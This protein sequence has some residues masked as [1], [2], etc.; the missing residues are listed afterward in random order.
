MANL[1]QRILDAL[2]IEKFYTEVGDLVLG[3]TGTDYTALCCFH[4]ES[5]PSLVIRKKDGVF[6]CFGCEATGS[7]FDF[8]A[9]LKGVD[10]KEALGVLAEFAGVENDEAEEASDPTIGDVEEWHKALLKNKTRL[11]W[12]LDKRGITV[13]TVKHFKLGHDD[14][15]YTIPVYDN[16]ALVN[17]RKYLPNAP[18]GVY[19]VIGIKGRNERRL[20]RR[21]VFGLGKPILLC[22]GEMD[23]ILAW[24]SGF[25]ATTVTSGAGNWKAEWNE[26]FTSESVVLAYDNDKQGRVGT[27]KVGRFILTATDDVRV[28][29]WPEGFKDKGDVTDFLLGHSVEAFSELVEAAEVFVPTETVKHQFRFPLTDLGNAERLVARHGERFL[30]VTEWKSF[31]VWNGKSKWDSD[32]K[33]DVPGWAIETV[34]TIM[35]EAKELKSKDAADLLEKWQKTSE[36]AGKLEAMIDWAGKRS[37]IGAE[38]FNK[39]PW[40][41]NTPTGVIN[42]KQ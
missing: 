35:E 30:W 5:K 26:L 36:S 28:V 33:A 7:V 37:S 34:R 41:L 29:K 14:E 9:K 38:S 40:L 42:L 39:D 2:D 10:F 6:T 8:Y 20:F 16:G 17:V 11:K 4:D 13:E 18:Q 1:R 22:E 25:N 19:K 27:E 3:D 24:Q 31:L 15:R 12:L 21:D 23:C 32:L